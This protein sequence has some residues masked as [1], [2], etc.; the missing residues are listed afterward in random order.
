MSSVPVHTII[1]LENL[2][3]VSQE[4]LFFLYPEWNLHTGHG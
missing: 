1:I 4:F 2:I 3:S